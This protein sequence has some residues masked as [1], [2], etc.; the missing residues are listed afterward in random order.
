MLQAIT[1]ILLQAVLGN[2]MIHGLLTISFNSTLQN[3]SL[4]GADRKRRKQKS[5]SVY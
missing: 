2:T 4:E 5:N 3:K 1:P